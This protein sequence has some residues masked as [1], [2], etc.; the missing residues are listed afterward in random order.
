MKIFLK[1]IL[2]SFALGVGMLLH[3]EVAN[4]ASVAVDTEYGEM[5]LIQD[6]YE[7]YLMFK[8]SDGLYV[9]FYNGDMACP[10]LSDTKAT[11]SFTGD[12]VVYSTENGYI[13][14]TKNG[15]TV[16]VNYTKLPYYATNKAFTYT[17]NAYTVT[18]EA[19]PYITNS[20]AKDASVEMLDQYYGTAKGYYVLRSDGTIKMILRTGNYW[21]LSTTD[22]TITLSGSPEKATVI[23]YDGSGYTSEYVNQVCSANT[24]LLFK[25]NKEDL[26]LFSNGS[27]YLADETS[28]TGTYGDARTATFDKFAGMTAVAVDIEPTVVSIVVP[29]N[30]S[31]TINV[32]AED[33]LV[34][35]DIIIQNNTKAP[36]KISLAALASEDLPF[37][38]LIHPD[39]LPDTLAW[40]MLNAADSM[41]YFALG[42]KPVDTDNTP[43]KSMVSDYVWTTPDL[44]ETE[45]GVVEASSSSNLGLSA[46]FGRTQTQ[47]NAFTFSA[48][49]V[50]EL[51]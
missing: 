12:F 38:N 46:Y 1:S 29:L 39:D 24:A 34:H 4:A 20:E 2:F 6:S 30:V 23:T 40:D 16:A 5:T 13:P 11:L 48:T 43:W 15:E 47:K 35:G 8:Q 18:F 41:K 25:D 51:E 9:V 50:A 49:F 42:I 44:T 7:N 31:A 32:N 14:E 45:L 36:V 17:A 33:G 27:L 28:H 3:A 22:G 37:T 10:A 26:Y 21:R 19:R